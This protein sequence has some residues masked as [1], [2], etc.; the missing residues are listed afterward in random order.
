M[1][2]Y[3]KSRFLS[4]PLVYIQEGNT[5]CSYDPR[6]E[7]Q[8]AEGEIP[9]AIMKYV[10][11]ITEA[12]ADDL[13][14]YYKNAAAGRNSPLPATL[15]YVAIAP[16]GRKKLGG[17]L[18]V[19][20]V[21]L[22]L[23]LVGGSMMAALVDEFLGQEI[24]S[25]PAVAGDS[26]QH[27][28]WVAM[29]VVDVFG[30]MVLAAVPI[31]IFILM[32][33]RWAGTRRLM[34]GFCGFVVFVA[35]FDLVTATG[36]GIDSLR[37]AGLDDLATDLTVQAVSGVIGA[38]FALAFIPYFLVSERVRDTFTGQPVAPPATTSGSQWSGPPFPDASPPS[39]PSAGPPQW[40]PLPPSAPPAGAVASDE[41]QGVERFCPR[42]GAE[43]VPDARFCVRCGRQFD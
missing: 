3:Y 33:R 41:P 34:V 42:C 14:V 15:G 7:T 28:G 43:R 26:G 6:A 19:A 8:V 35:V 17:F 21:W 30:A 5:W 4:Q 29:I 22:A 2:R 12:E 13:I 11:E 31:I 23:T 24:L 25:L 39:W 1:A 20:I 9:E 27:A 37:A 10:T 18:I 32:G 38:A 36:F 16:A 40:E